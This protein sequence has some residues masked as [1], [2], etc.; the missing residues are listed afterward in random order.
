MVAT[1]YLF[2]MIFIYVIHFRTG[3]VIYFWGNK[4]DLWEGCWSSLLKCRK[5]YTHT[6]THTWI[7]WFFGLC[8]RAYNLN[9]FVKVKENTECH[10]NGI[11]ADSFMTWLIRD[12]LSHTHTQCVASF[13]A[14][15]LRCYTHARARTHTHTQIS[16]VTIVCVF[17]CVYV[18]WSSLFKLKWT[19][20]WSVH[21]FKWWRMTWQVDRYFIS[22]KQKLIGISFHPNRHGK[23]IGTHFCVQAKVNMELIG[24]W[25]G[26]LIG[27]NFTQTASSQTHAWHDSY[28]I[29]S[30]SHTHTPFFAVWR[31]P[32]HRWCRQYQ[33]PNLFLWM[34][35]LCDMTH[36][37]WYDSFVVTWLM[38][39]DMTQIY[40]CECA[41]CVTWLIRGDMTHSWWHDSSMVTWQIYSC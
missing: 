7:V 4:T 10:P 27:T 20:S 6:H 22:P 37:W 18:I 5:T 8:M 34:C 40:S 28:V 39:G 3:N 25:H 21:L 19:R 30:L 15:A 2:I 33:N 11:I 9:T 24:T 31:A 26:K 38:H 17:V 23:L 1:P 41:L 13:A 14:S 32:T 35:H 16:R 29:L 36:S 12:S